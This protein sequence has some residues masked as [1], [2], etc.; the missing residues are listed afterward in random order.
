LKASLSIDAFSIDRA[1]PSIH[2]RGA[3]LC[4][5]DYYS[6]RLS[7]ETPLVSFG[8]RNLDY[9]GLFKVKFASL[10][11]KPTSILDLAKTPRFMIT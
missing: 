7:Q 5:H 1:A 4:H 6:N 8:L 3:K 10:R 2:S 11:L 9:A